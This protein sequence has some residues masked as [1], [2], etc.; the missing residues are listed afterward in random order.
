MATATR[1][2]AT[3]GPAGTQIVYRDMLWVSDGGGTTG[4]WAG[5]TSLAVPNIYVSPGGSLRFRLMGNLYNPSA[6]TN[7]SVNFRVQ[8]TGAGVA[9]VN[10]HGFF[11][12]GNAASPPSSHVTVAGEATLGGLAEGTYSFTVEYKQSINNALAC[13]AASAAETDGL[14]I[15]VE[16]YE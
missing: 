14:A 12:T 15:Q 8:V 10:L 6:V 13:N 11:E 4:T 2:P 9:T 5:L 1:L 16:E 3:A 7:G